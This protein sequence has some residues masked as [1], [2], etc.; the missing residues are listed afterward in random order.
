MD[1]PVPDY[2][3][4]LDSAVSYTK[5]RNCISTALYLSGV[6]LQET[7]AID[8]LIAWKR[9]FESLEEVGNPI[10]GLIV[11]WTDHTAYNDSGI[12]VHHA[13][14]ITGANGGIRVT[15]KI[16]NDGPMFVD[17]LIEKAEG[18]RYSGLSRRFFLPGIHFDMRVGLQH[19][20]PS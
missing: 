1:L 11:A 4:R 16:K 15:H 14:V 7:P 9:A 2:W 5:G 18:V 17:D 19:E 3:R 20:R 8:T 12:R 13:G 10:V 6:N